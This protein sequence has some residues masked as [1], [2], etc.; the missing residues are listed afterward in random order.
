[1][2]ASPQNSYVLRQAAIFYLRS[3]KRDLAEPL[4]RQMIAIQSPAALAN[5]C[6]AR[7]YLAGILRDRGNFTD[8][9]Q[10]MALIDENLRS[11][12]PAIE[13]KRA[14][15]E[16]LLADP[17]KEKIG[18]AVQAMEELMQAADATPD[19]SFTLAKLYLKKGDWASFDKRMQNVLGNQKGTVQ[20]AILFFYIATLLDKKQF[21][22]ADNWLKTLEKEDKEKEKEMTPEERAALTHNFFDTVRLRAEYHFLRGEYA[23]ALNLM[24]DF[25]ANPDSQ[26]KDRGQQLLLSALAVEKFGDRLKTMDKAGEA[27]RFSAKADELFNSLKSRA[28]GDIHFAAYLGRQKRT[29]ECL[30][31]LEQCWDKCPVESLGIAA[32]ALM[33]LNKLDDTQSARLEK[34]VV[35]A[36]NKSNRPV[37]LLTLLAELHGLQREYDKT[38]ADYREILAKEPRNIEAMN[39]LGLN[40]VR[41]GKNVD[42]ALKLI[43]ETLDIRGPMAELL[44]SRAV[45]YI[46]L[47]EYDKALDDLAAAIKDNGDAEECFHQ[48]LGLLVGWEEA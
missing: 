35:A 15:V 4:L 44:D 38:S 8:L 27:G 37:T 12:T 31:V 10:A 40:L 17:R 11:K 32:L 22:D 3:G 6:W 29:A 45:V 1:M 5:V 33:R 46:A 25:L 48:G 39:N 16:F 42:E 24:M 36:A 14:K 47:H 41:S 18:K 34:I 19:D 2:K 23:A 28:G 26:P 20:P 43:N 30:N 7:R 21:N 13:D 9:C